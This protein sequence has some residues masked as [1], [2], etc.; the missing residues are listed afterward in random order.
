M[1]VPFASP[2]CTARGF[3]AKT[4]QGPHL[5]AQFYYEAATVYRVFC[6]PSYGTGRRPARAGART[7]GAWTP[8]T[9]PAGIQNALAGHAN[10]PRRS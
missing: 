10:L 9:V 2:H 8:A 1:P 4:P 6:I 5:M 7:N 3:R